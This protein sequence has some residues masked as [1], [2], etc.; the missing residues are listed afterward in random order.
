[1]SHDLFGSDDAVSFHLTESIR[2]KWLAL[3]G[4]LLHR[5]L[6]TFEPIMICQTMGCIVTIRIGGGLMLKSLKEL[7]SESLSG[8]V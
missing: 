5:I 2:D 1:M 7:V 6:M 8:D 4:G 3:L